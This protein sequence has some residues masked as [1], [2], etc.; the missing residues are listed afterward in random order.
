MMEIE[1]SRAR[2]EAEERKW[3]AWSEDNV[4]RKHNYVPLLVE[5]LKQ[6]SRN[7]SMD[8]CIENAKRKRTEEVAAARKRKA[9]A[10]ASS[11]T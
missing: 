5:L 1:S 10:E 2:L 8:E 3:K 7:A 11:T 6:L 9:E 4:R